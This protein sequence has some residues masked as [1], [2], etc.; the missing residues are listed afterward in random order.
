MCRHVNTSMDTHA[1]THINGRTFPTRAH[2]SCSQLPKALAPCTS[3]CSSC[4]LSFA[5]WRS[6]SCRASVHHSST[7]V[8]KELLLCELTDWEGLLAGD[9]APF[10][11]L[12]TKEDSCCSIIEGPLVGSSRAANHQASTCHYACVG[13]RLAA[14]DTR[15]SPLPARRPKCASRKIP[16]RTQTRRTLRTAAAAAAAAV[17][18]LGSWS[19]RGGKA[20]Q[21]AS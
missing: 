18:V 5:K 2:R 21:C 4:R 11:Y 15:F 14:V 16:A 20:L 3:A 13:R 1:H 9:K 10:L 12:L 7:C 17:V 8:M 6:V 19:R